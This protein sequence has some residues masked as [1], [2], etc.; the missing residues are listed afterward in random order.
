[1]APVVVLPNH[2]TQKLSSSRNL[3]LH[4]WL[5]EQ[6]S[7]SQVDVFQHE[8]KES[9]DE[10]D[11]VT[12]TEEEFLSGQVAYNR[13]AR[14]DDFK[15]CLKNTKIKWDSC[16]QNFVEEVYCF[17][18]HP[19]CYRALTQGYSY[20]ACKVVIGYRQIKYHSKCPALQIDC[21]CAAWKLHLWNLSTCVHCI[22]GKITYSYSVNDPHQC[23]LCSN[24]ILAGLKIIFEM[25]ERKN[26]FRMS[27]ISGHKSLCK[28]WSNY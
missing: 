13:T 4:H 17:S 7:Q 26:F 6:D 8:A 11:K 22:N 21:Q 27:E 20:T 12:K 2:W 28:I 16:R 25:W 23:S 15:P 24:C 5:R 10:K 18:T 1:M 19:A 9:I 3:I 14:D